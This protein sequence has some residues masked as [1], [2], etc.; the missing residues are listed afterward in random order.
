M[1]GGGVGDG[2]GGGD[3]REKCGGGVDA[4]AVE[5]IARPH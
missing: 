4:P 3:P 5:V 2:G 1:S